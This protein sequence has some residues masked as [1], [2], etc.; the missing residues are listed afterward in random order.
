MRT[1]N[2]LCVCVCF[3]CSLSQAAERPTLLKTN[4]PRPDILPRP[5]Y[6][7]H[8]EYRA[9]YN[10]PRFYTGW[11]AYEVSRTS[12]EAMVWQENYCAGNY[13][14]HHMPPV[15]K[16][17][18]YP[19]PWE[20]LNVGARPDF[21]SANP[22]AQRVPAAIKS[23]E[24]NVK[25]MEQASKP[26]IE[27]A[28]APATEGDQGKVEPSEAKPA[29]DTKRELVPS[30][31]DKASSRSTSTKQRPV[32]TKPSPSSSSASQPSTSK[33]SAGKASS[34]KSTAKKAS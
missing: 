5:F 2:I 12:Q 32:S 10:R 28:P 11:L 30:P 24:S 20:V 7:N 4:D 16:T 14:R 34:S 9:Q 22:K 18:Y 19:K 33:P 13:D 31:S 25:P 6:D 8:T 17:Y 15:C 21:A 3:T 27:A 26:A 23:D 1:F 29:E